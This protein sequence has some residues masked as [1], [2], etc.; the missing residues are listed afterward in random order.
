M[1]SSEDG[2]PFLIVAQLLRPRGLWKVQH[3]ESRV[4]LSPTAL[5]LS[6]SQSKIACRGTEIWKHDVRLSVCTQ[7]PDWVMQGPC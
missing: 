2:Q 1:G 7:N 4:I 6:R 3:L 5:Q